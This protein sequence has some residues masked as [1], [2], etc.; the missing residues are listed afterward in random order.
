MTMIEINL[1]PEEFKQQKKKQLFA[2]Q[3]QLLWYIAPLFLGLLII[4]HLYFAGAFLFKTFQYK[5]LNNKW[6]QLGAQLQE[7]N[8]WKAQYKT[9]SQQA[10]KINKLLAQRVSVSDKMQ[11]LVQTLLKGIWFN[12]LN[13]KN[14]QFNLTG[15]VVSLKKDHMRLLNIFLSQLKED[16]HFFKDFL[17]LE[18]GRVNMRLIGAYSIMDFVLEGDLR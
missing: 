18:L 6:A 12:R 17:R 7:V 10:G 15:T 13:F 1:L 14:K 9:S 5:T 8:E 16:N 3:A 11:V 2:L 4:A